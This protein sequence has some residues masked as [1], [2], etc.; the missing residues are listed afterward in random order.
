MRGKR[1]SNPLAPAKSEHLACGA[2]AV[3]GKGKG[4]K[5]MTPHPTP[6][7]LVF[8]GLGRICRIGW[9]FK[10]NHLLYSSSSCFFLSLSFCSD[11]TVMVDWVQ[12]TKLLLLLLL[13]L[14]L[15]FSLSLFPALSLSLPVPLS[16]F[17][18]LGGEKSDF[19]GVREKAKST[20]LILLCF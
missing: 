18:S 9:G 4:E 17:V 8:S 15:A 10:T 16:V 11:I 6:Y 7:F 1:G 19:V 20:Q 13:C 14:S 3:V 2:P 12:N 5:C